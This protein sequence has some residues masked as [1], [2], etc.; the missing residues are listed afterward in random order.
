MGGNESIC[1]Y[2]YR[3]PRVIHE[4]LTEG[5]TKGEGQGKWD[6]E[7]LEDGKYLLILFDF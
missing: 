6:R 3:Y 7:R 1:L 5:V 4:T 2:P